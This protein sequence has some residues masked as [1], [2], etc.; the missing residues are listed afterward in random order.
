MMLRAPTL[1][2]HAEVA[3]TVGGA[4]WSGKSGS[5]GSETGSVPAAD[6]VAVSPDATSTGKSGSIGG[7]STMKSGS[8]ASTPGVWFAQ[9]M[10]SCG[11]A[12]G[13]DSEKKPSPNDVVVHVTTGRSVAGMAGEP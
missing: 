7:A 2:L 5:L 11:S 10:T 12:A 6:A 4:H 9:S 1:T 3:E 8:I 13:A